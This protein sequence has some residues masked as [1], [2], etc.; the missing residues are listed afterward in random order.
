MG[1]EN[2]AYF[3]ITPG[4]ET[5]LLSTSAVIVPEKSGLLAIA[6]ANS[7]KVFNVDGD[8]SITDVTPAVAALLA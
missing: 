2:P 1:A 8:V 6:P 5:N 7:F 4:W 3:F